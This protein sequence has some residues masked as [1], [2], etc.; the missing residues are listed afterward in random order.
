MKNI[1]LKTTD[2]PGK[3]FRDLYADLYRKSFIVVDDKLIV[4]SFPL[5]LLLGFVVPWMVSR[6]EKKLETSSILSFVVESVE[7]VELNVDIGAS[8]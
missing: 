3:V 8:F 4:F 7:G 1:F 2:Q 5:H 6:N